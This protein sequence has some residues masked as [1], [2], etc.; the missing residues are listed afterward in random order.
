MIESILPSKQ[1]QLSRI[2]ENRFNLDP[3]HF[4]IHAGPERINF[5]VYDRNGGSTDKNNVFNLAYYPEAHRFHLSSIRE[6]NG[7]DQTNVRHTGNEILSHL[8]GAAKD[9][10]IQQ[11]HIGQ[12]RSNLNIPILDEDETVQINMGKLKTLQTGQSWYNKHRFFG[13]DYDA[14]N[15]RNAHIRSQLLTHYFKP[16]QRK[17]D[18]AEEFEELF[19]IPLEGLTVADF[20][21]FTQNLIKKGIPVSRDKIQLVKNIL[22]K[23][24]LRQEEGELTFI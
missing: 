2:L 24:P 17:Y 14:I 22:E 21:A 15:E 6:K 16:M 9:M 23:I 3:T 10:G 8:K 18:A 5:S 4:E 11:F 13:E 20:G 19:K 7:I 12:D 1:T